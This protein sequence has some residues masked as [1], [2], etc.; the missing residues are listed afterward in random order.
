MLTW[1]KT[2]EFE[3]TNNNCMDENLTIDDMKKMDSIGHVHKVQQY[4]RVQLYYA[5]HSFQLVI[6]DVLSSS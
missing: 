3:H 4:Y 5:S 6:C 1:M 2:D